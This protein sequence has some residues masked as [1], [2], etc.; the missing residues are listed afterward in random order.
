[1]C[2]MLEEN[3][4]LH[5]PTWQEHP[6]SDDRFYRGE[7]AVDGI[8]KDRSANGGKC[9]ISANNESTALWRVDLGSVVS[10]SHIVIYYRT[11]NKPGMKI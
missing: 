2:Y 4:A 7:N 9:T 6:W 8:Y 3:I 11:D 1:M 5:K 10:I